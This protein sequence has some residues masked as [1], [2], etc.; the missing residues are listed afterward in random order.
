MA[1]TPEGARRQGG[2][3]AYILPILILAAAAAA[4]LFPRPV[5]EWF[6]MEP[7]PPQVAD[8]MD[9]IIRL[10]AVP[11]GFLGLLLLAFVSIRRSAKSR[12]AGP[13]AAG[14]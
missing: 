5:T 4:Y 13:E 9:N 6:G 8:D 2:I 3:G 7:T 10:I 14:S 1:T 12:R 11:V